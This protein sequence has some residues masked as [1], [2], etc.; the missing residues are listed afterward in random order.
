MHRI[1]DGSNPDEPSIQEFNTRDGLYSV[2]WRWGPV[3]MGA[4]PPQVVSANATEG[5]QSVNTH[6]G[7]RLQMTRNR[8]PL[9]TR[10]Y[11]AGDNPDSMLM[12]QEFGVEFSFPMS[13]YLSR[14]TMNLPADIAT[15]YSQ[16]VQAGLKRKFLEIVNSVSAKFDD[17]EILQV[18]NQ[19]LLHLTLN[20]VLIPLP[21]A[22]DGITAIASIAL[23]I[24]T[25]PRGIVV[26]DEF[27]ASVHYTRLRDTWALFHKLCLEYD[28]QIIAATHSRECVEE[29]F[30][31]ISEMHKN[32]VIY[33]RLD[34]VNGENIATPYD[35]DDMK[36]INAERWEFR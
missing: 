21:F 34:S 7:Y 17:V 28:T 25:S 27:D 13:A 4:T 30:D 31:G 14:T 20:N 24:M 22:G 32:D 23:A 12:K 26:I 29:L 5:S 19:P 33:Y 2:E 6:D 11:S 3:A 8:S 10:L 15:R 36:E 18:A 16:I 1:N 35:W 9:L